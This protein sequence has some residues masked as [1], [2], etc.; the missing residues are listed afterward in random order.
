[1]NSKAILIGK[2][3]EV[4][5]MRRID[6]AEES[7]SLIILRHFDKTLVHAKNRTLYFIEPTGPQIVSYHYST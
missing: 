5:R 1:M 7:Y 6:D 3:T 2:S 4:S